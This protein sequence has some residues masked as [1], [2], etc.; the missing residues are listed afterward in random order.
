MLHLFVSGGLFAVF[1]RV[2]C[3]ERYAFEGMRFPVCWRGMWA[4][5]GVV[6]GLVLRGVEV[7]YG[8]GGRWGILLVV[9]NYDRIG[10]ADV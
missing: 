9:L 1:A 5:R 6:W 2:A 10:E 8:D 3:R 4:V 7:S